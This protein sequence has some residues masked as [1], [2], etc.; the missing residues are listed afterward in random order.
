MKKL[1]KGLVA[2]TVLMLALTACG[3]KSAT[4]TFTHDDN[5]IATEMTYTYEG[6][7]ITRL[8]MKT[9]MPF[10]SMMIENKEQAEQTLEIMK[11]TAQDVEGITNE[12]FIDGE[13]IVMTSMVDY[14]KVNLE[15]ISEISGGLTIDPEEV[16]SMKKVEETLVSQGFTVK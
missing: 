14:A 4:K 3:S 7:K 5:G 6:D 12:Y 8:D 1:I 10:A 13:N 2:V 15:K 9:V 16:T 11:S